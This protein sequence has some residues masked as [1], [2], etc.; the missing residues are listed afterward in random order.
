MSVLKN[1]IQIAPSDLFTQISNVSTTVPYNTNTP[2]LGSMMTTGDGRYFRYVQAG[3]SA[4]IV[5]QLQQSAA[6][7]ANY[8]DV[9]AVA[10][11]AG[12]TSATLTVSTGTA[13][14]ANQF[15]GG[16]Y[17]TYGTVA[18]GGGQNVRIAGN[19]AVTSSG[20]SIT[21][22]FDEPIGAA[23]TT[24]ATVTIVPP[25]YSGIIQ[26]PTT[27]T[28]K[29]AGVAV[30]NLAA[31]YYGWLQVKGLSNVLI[32]GIPAAQSGLIQPISGTAGALQVQ[33]STYESIAINL[34][35]GVNGQY[36]PVDL[37]IS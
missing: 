33:S 32:A 3:A 22:T 10:V 19:T 1:E 15:A 4:L 37:R 2:D 24:S 35:T 6:I 36:G 14:A 30:T 18:N 7:Q 27:A 26:V 20:T 12:A 16:F 11:A 21:L 29:I 9:T 28:G 34:K 25:A 23:V 8:T 31:S 5:G 13:V 17:T